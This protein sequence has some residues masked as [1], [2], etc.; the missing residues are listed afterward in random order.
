MRLRL[1]EYLD[2]E[3]REHFAGLCELLGAGRYRLY[4]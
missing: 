1:G 4:R 2:E 3:S